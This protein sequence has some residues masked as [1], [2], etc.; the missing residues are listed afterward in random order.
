MEVKDVTAVQSRELVSQTTLEHTEKVDK[1]VDVASAHEDIVE[2]SSN[3]ELKKVNEYRLETNKA[4][5]S[6]NVTVDAADRMGKIVKTLDGLVQ[7][8]EALPPE[9]RAKL[10]EEGK[11]LIAEMKRL[12][13][14]VAESNPPPVS[15]E[16]IRGQV[17]RS[18]GRA[19]EAIFPNEGRSP[20]GVE[21][22]TLSTK[23][24]IIKTRSSVELVK[25][26]FESL[27]SSVS[28]V[29]STAMAL[30][31]QAE[32]ISAVKQHVPDR[33]RSVDDATKLTNEAQGSIKID[34][35]HAI[36]SVGETDVSHLTV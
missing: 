33:V 22:L 3:I 12:A 20:L 6:A 2:V 19:L 24:A 7:Q 13:K 15:N 18:L 30:S 29:A 16:D 9:A 10:E 23:E 21:D 8:A 28:H 27:R 26:Q 17:E 14:Q 4:I 25:A 31:Q 34:P 5:N 35:S 32:T 11:T 1:P 36:Q